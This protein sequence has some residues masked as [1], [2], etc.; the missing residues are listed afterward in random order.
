MK[1]QPRS[2]KSFAWHHLQILFNVKF[3]CIIYN[4]IEVFIIHYS[5]VEIWQ[6]IYVQDTRHHKMEYKIQLYDVFLL[7]NKSFFILGWLWPSQC[8]QYINSELGPIFT[9]LLAQVSAIKLFVTTFVCL[10]WYCQ[11]V[12]T[13]QKFLNLNWISQL[14]K[15]EKV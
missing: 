4:K 3:W 8:W 13:L 2:W 12:F 7:G 11:N 1:I 10:S 14:G 6:C 9:K 15:K 5:S